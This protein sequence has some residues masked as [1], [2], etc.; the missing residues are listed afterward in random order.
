MSTKRYVR[1][2]SEKNQSVGETEA[3]KWI[4]TAWQYSQR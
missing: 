2:L 4:A 3:T 1:Q